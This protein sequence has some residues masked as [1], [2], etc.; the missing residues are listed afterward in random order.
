MRHLF[1]YQSLNENIGHAMTLMKAMNMN[2][3]RYVYRESKRPGIRDV[4]VNLAFYN[5]YIVS[6]SSDMRKFINTLLRNVK[7]VKRVDE[8]IKN[9]FQIVKK[10]AL[11]STLILYEKVTKKELEGHHFGYHNERWSEMT[12]LT[13]KTENHVARIAF[14]YSHY[15]GAIYLVLEDLDPSK[16]K[17]YMNVYDIADDYRQIKTGDYDEDNRTYGSHDRI[18]IGSIENFKS[19]VDNLL[20]LQINMWKSRI[21]KDVNQINN[22]P[23]YILSKIHSDKIV[24]VR[25]I[26]IFDTDD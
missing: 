17:C 6:S 24:K 15:R 9:A 1:T 22:C 10:V 2:Y 21:E 25:D 12:G 7:K 18:P 13:Y 26:G 19:A 16:Q 14:D 8:Y 3:I 20:P 11:K 4:I 5:G 23:E